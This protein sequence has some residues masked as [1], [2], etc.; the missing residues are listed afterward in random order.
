[1]ITS[2]IRAFIAIDLTPEIRQRLDQ[3]SN[4]LQQHLENVPVR[5]VTAGNIHLTLKFL[6]DVSVNNL[7]MVKKI[8]QKEVEGHPSFEISVGGVGAFPTEK[9]PRVIWVGVEAPQELNMIQHGIE[10]AAALLGYAKEERAFSPHLTLGRVSR[11]ATS[12]DTHLIGEVLESTKI[13]FIGVTN[14]DSV[15]LYR[16]DLKQTGSVYTRIST[17]ALKG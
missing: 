5:W 13:G 15:H 9:H 16:S 10:T 11:N 7:E 3:V 2:V 1:M 14:V 4:Q 8:L 6:G 12:R 17:A